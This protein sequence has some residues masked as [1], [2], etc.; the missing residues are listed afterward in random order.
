METILEILLSF[1]FN[2]AVVF[3]IIRFIY[4]P[5]TRNKDYIFTFFAFNTIIFFVLR[6][7]SSINL[8][9]GLGFGLFAI[10]SVLRYRTNP[11]PIR[12]MTYIFIIIALPV[13][14]S[15][16]LSENG[17][18]P[19]LIANLLILIV[20]FAIEKGWGFKFD[21]CFGY[22][23]RPIGHIWNPLYFIKKKTLGDIP[24]D[25]WEDYFGEEQAKRMK[26][27]Y[28]IKNGYTAKYSVYNP[29]YGKYWFVLRLPKWIPTL[30]FSF[31]TPW[32]SFYIGNK[33]YRI[34][35]FENDMSWTNKKDEER[36]R[37]LQPEDLYYAL[38]PSLSIRSGRS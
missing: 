29:W 30:Y 5:Q 16:L 4:Y 13:M 11:I 38:C 31:N 6:L 25:E 37:R 7:L 15:V 23:I 17:F 12:E 1:I 14:N 32:K 9:I 33:A 8:S 19:L 18:S 27:L 36:A 28:E 2:F 22:T 26:K 3:T 35:P 24:L 21:I 10:F 20:L 34:D